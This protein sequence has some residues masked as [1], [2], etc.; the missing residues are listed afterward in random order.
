V[1]AQFGHVLEPTAKV[2]GAEV[3]MP[4][5]AAGVAGGRRR[6]F[7]RAEGRGVGDSVDCCGDGPAIAAAV[8]SL[9]LVADGRG[10]G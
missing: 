5:D 9:D 1:S 6:R 3:Q 2:A 10:G 7:G 4:D 8:G